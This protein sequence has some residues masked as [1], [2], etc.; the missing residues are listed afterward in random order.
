MFN[1]ILSFFFP[2][3]CI[4]CDRVLSFC[5]D[6][7]CLC[8]DCKKRLTFLQNMKTCEKCGRP[9]ED[10]QSLCE[11]CQTHQHGFIRGHAA[12][13]YTGQARDAILR[14]KFHHRRDYCRTFAAL[15]YQRLKLYYEGT[16]FD[17]LVCVPLS[18]ESMR[19]RGYNQSDLLAKEISRKMHLSY[20]KK[21]F[22]KI[23][24]TQKQSTLHYIER[25]ENVHGAY[26]LKASQAHFRGKRILLIDDVLTTG[27]TV[28]ELSRLLKRAG[29][30]SVVAAAIASPERNRPEKLPQPDL[31]ED[32]F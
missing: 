11:T 9:I 5:A 16:D 24:E 28:D 14:F 3:R 7:I 2:D 25:W 18:E 4:V 26:A 15:I 22:K 10:D 13:L 23:R 8:D 29:A 32:V 30:H 27:A 12:L 17:L 1:R 31:E 19:K 6:S 21:A 20:H